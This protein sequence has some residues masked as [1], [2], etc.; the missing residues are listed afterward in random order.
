MWCRCVHRG[1][2]SLQITAYTRRTLRAGLLSQALCPHVKSIVGVDI[3]QGSV[4]QYNAQV[5]NQGLAPEEMRAV[6]MEL[7]G[8]PGELDD[9]KF[10]LIVVSS[11]ASCRTNAWLTR[12]A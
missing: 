10:D 12:V 3:S 8:V 5:S 11:L 9:V 7:K 4:E 1:A 6:C 2:R